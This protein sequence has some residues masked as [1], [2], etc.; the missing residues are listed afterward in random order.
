MTFGHGGRLQSDLGGDEEI[1]ALARQPDAK[2]VALGSYTEGGAFGRT[3]VARYR[4]QLVCVVPNVVRRS[5][6]RARGVLSRAGCRAG[7]VTRR[8]AKARAGL[9]V[10][11]RPRAG[12]QIPRGGRVALVVSRGR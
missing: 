12:Q 11:Q 6:N 2:V 5:L 1:V 7:K 10:R 4:A 8:R 9:V 3:L